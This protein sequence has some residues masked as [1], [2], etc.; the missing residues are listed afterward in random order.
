MKQLLAL[1][2][3]VMIL[4]AACKKD[5]DEISLKGKWNLENAIYKE[6]ENGV[7]INTETEAGDGTTLDFQNNGNVV[8]T[9]P[10][11]P[12]ESL[13]YTIKADSKVEIDGDTYEIRNLNASNVTL[14]IRED[15]AQG[16]Y[17]EISLNLKR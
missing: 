15:Y 8:I 5:K 10:G 9:S 11:T 12:S 7:L 13:S 6:Y 4:L 2:M 16:M 17:D 14:Y 1:S 3:I